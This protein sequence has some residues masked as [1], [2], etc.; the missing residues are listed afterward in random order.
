ML[1]EG[2]L[3]KIETL[4]NYLYLFL[5]VFCLALKSNA[6]TDTVINGK[7]YKMVE[8]KTSTEKVKKKHIAPLD[9]TFVINNKKFRHYNNWV[10][11]GAGVQQNLTR[12]YPLGFTGGVDFNFHIKHHYFQLGTNISGE[13]FGFY[14]NYQFHG[15]YGKRYEDKDIHFSG[16]A[17]VSYSTG[18]G[19]VDSIY[20]RPYSQPGIYLQ[21][22]IIKKVTYDV[23][24]GASLYA[25]W[26]AEQA[27]AGIRFI[28]YFS[29]AYNGKKFRSAE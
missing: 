19:L 1:R 25:D 11:A 2:L 16:F 15:G 5:L 14:N 3:F 18:Y 6:Q 21:V 29:G 7:T 4:K 26:N 28:V 13:K 17:G 9:S 24:V 10:T 23:G 22:D 20:S 12:K 27:M 8:E